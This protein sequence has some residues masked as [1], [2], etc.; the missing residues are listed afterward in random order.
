[1]GVTPPREFL[2]L[3]HSSLRTVSCS[4]VTRCRIR[5]SRVTFSDALCQAA[6]ESTFRAG[7]RADKFR[8]CTRV[9]PANFSEGD[10]LRRRSTRAAR[11]GSATSFSR[12][13]I[14][15][16]YQVSGGLEACTNSIAGK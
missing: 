1:P 4:K 8:F 14:A 6:C 16:K 12:L 2:A 5:S 11:L 15:G 10:R 9:E 7:I 13:R 3:R